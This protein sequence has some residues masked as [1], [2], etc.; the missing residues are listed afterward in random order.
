MAM[1]WE[2]LS[3][4]WGTEEHCI[5]RLAASAGS[6]LYAEARKTDTTEKRSAI[7]PTSPDTNLLEG[8]YLI[9]LHSGD[10][11]RQFLPKHVVLPFL[12]G[13]MTFADEQQA[14][15]PLGNDEHYP[16]VSLMS[17]TQG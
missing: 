3:S 5:S 10:R 15:L 16:R 6:T 2:P 11:C 1:S 13:Y 4:C 8:H 7:I 12:W 9:A 17:I 14:V